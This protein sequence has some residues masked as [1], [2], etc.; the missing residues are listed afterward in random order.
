M[1]L[2]TPEGGSSGVCERNDRI[3]GCGNTT[4][5]MAGVGTGASTVC[6]LEGPAPGVW[7][8][9]EWNDGGRE[10]G[11]GG[12]RGTTGDM[13]DAGRDGEAGVVGDDRPLRP[14][15]IA[16]TGVAMATG[17]GGGGAKYPSSTSAPMID[18]PGGGVGGGLSAYDS[19]SPTTPPVL[20]D[21]HETSVSGGPSSELVCS[22]DGAAGGEYGGG[23]AWMT[24]P[25]KYLGTKGAG[26]CIGGPSSD[27]SVW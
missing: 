4:G 8:F 14:A 2:S 20:R 3:D 11:G 26:P 7:S 10:D 21:D 24:V 17:N 18:P 6:E 25:G 19:L 13:G 23:A 22:F 9:V 16:G 27:A 5:C 1:S 12:R 15:R